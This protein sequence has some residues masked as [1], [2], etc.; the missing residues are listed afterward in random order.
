MSSGLNILVLKV[1]KLAN[2]W[3]DGR[4]SILKALAFLSEAS[5]RISEVGL[6]FSAVTA[7]TR[8][9][10]VLAGA[11]VFCSRTVLQS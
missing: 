2:T 9:S 7:V 11:G 1:G 8:F 5:A 6:N 4:W 10:T 3:N